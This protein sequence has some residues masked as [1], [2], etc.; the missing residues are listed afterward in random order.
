M[1][2]KRGVSLRFNASLQLKKSLRKGCKLY[3]VIAMNKKG[4]RMNS[5]QH[6]IL[7]EFP[8]M[9]LEESLGILPKREIEFMIELKLGTKH[10]SKVPYHMPTSKL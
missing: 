8:D 9:F 4:D 10:I 2:T 6:P 1:G 5:V 3:G 7:L